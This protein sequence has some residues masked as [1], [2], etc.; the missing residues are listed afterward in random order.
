MKHSSFTLIM[1]GAVLMSP[2]TNSVAQIQNSTY[3]FEYDA[4]GNL[5][6]VID[7]LAHATQYG[8][9]KLDRRTTETTDNLATAKLSYD[10]LNQLTKVVDQRNLA[11]TYAISGTGGRTDLISPDTGASAWTLDA[12]GNVLTS[13]DAKGQTSTYKYDI[14]NRVTDVQFADGTA[15]SYLYDVG[16]NAIGRLS[17]ITDASGSIDYGY[18]E[19]GR[20]VS[21]L[22][23]IGADIY[24]TG[25][26]YEPGG[27]L[28]ALV[29]PSGR[30]CEYT[31]DDAGRI[32]T[33][34]SVKTDRR[35]ILVSHVEYMPFGG[36]R[37]V[38]F[39]NGSVYLRTYDLDGRVISY[40]LNGKVQ[41]LQYD[42]AGRLSGIEDSGAVANNV[43]YGY[44]VVNRLTSALTPT[45][46]WNYT[47]D[48]AGNRTKTVLNSNTTTL[49]YG[50]ASNRLIQLGAGQVIDSDANGSVSSN[51]RATFQFDVSG[52]M[53][54]TTTAAGTVTYRANAL[55]QRVQKT[56]PVSTTAFHYDSD[57]R[58]IA[59]NTG[60]LATDYVYLDDLPVAILK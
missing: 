39:G 3:N 12:A 24:T 27:H 43:M 25:Y 31:Y 41:T 35:V 4:N 10:G 11:T 40:T 7:P 55:G 5:K 21:E 34:S 56:T 30:I 36:I 37:A 8:Y 2:A 59:E 6:K 58:L 42:A 54:S 28:A 17:R 15:I 47:Y 23:K 49:A 26:R 18:D 13:R 22:R 48:A 19:F 33:I 51:G 45:V 46:A 44:D 29:Y 53:A 57:G 1:A 52:K 32:A 9:D 38:T 60:A 16:P 20:V 14:L 50:S